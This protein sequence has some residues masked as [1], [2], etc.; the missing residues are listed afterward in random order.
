MS[1]ATIDPSSAVATLTIDDN[2]NPSQNPCCVPYKGG[3]VI[4]TMSQGCVL[5]FDHKIDCS[6]TITM[7][8]NDKRTINLY[9][10]RNDFAWNYAIS[11]LEQEP[12]RQHRPGTP[13]GGGSIMISGTGDY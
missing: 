9:Q 4:Q 2:L 10:V 13:T 7:Q 3:L 6:H 8:P 1:E 5:T 12:N 11:P